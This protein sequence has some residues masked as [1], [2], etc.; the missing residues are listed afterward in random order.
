MYYTIEAANNKG[1]DQTVRMQSHDKEDL[2]CI[3]EFIK[4]VREKD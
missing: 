2:T 4:R 1:A 3:I